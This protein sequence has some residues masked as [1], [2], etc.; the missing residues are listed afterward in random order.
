MLTNYP[1]ICRNLYLP[2]YTLFDLETTGVSCRS[3]DVV[4]ISALRVRGGAVVNSF[5][6][7]VN[8]G[9]HIPGAASQVNHITDEMVA[10]APTMEEVLPEFLAFIGEDV[11]VGHNIA[12]FDMK[13]LHR[14]CT[15]RFGAVPGND[16]IDTLVFARTRLPG[17][18]SYALGALADHQPLEDIEGLFARLE[19]YAQ[20]QDKTE[21]QA[22]CKELNRRILAVKEAQEF[23]LGSIF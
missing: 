3:D 10:G 7:L 13:F 2:D 21:F 19:S 8:P 17:L 6:S 20:E 14:D 5:S 4:E 11:L 18:G 15:A 16:Y 1:G 9:R 12:R 22:A 23:N